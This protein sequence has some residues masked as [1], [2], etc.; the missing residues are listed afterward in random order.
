MN[1]VFIFVSFLVVV[2]HIFMFGGKKRHASLQTDFQKI[3][4][5]L[6]IF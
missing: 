4:L 6:Y 1:A 3:F 5:E 2:N